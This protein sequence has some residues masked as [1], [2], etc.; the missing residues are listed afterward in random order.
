MSEVQQLHTA[1]RRYLIDRSTY[2]SERYAQT[3]GP[4]SGRYSAEDLDAFPRYQVLDAILEEVER[5]SLEEFASVEELR[6]RIA[7]AG[8]TAQS[9]F[10]S[11]EMGEIERRAMAQ[12]RERFVSF[13]TDLSS[14]DLALIEPL[15]Y[16]RMLSDS[17]VEE[18]SKRLRGTWGVEGGYWFPLTDVPREDVLAF[19]AAEFR[20]EVS[21]EHVQ[22]ILRTRGVDHV[23]ELREYGPSYEMELSELD[24]VYAGAEGF[25]FSS[26]L[27]WIIYASHE[28]SITVGGEWLIA[29]IRRI[30]PS[31]EQWIWMPGTS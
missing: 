27:D 11:G 12:E 5:L 16:R 22:E 21:V 8:W 15:P 31:W 6:E 25:W 28:N 19:R 1:A 2:W 4:W 26:T 7:R 18:L 23:W 17:E 24:P 29:E 9:L 13:V 30:W 20:R 14:E 3:P 10:T